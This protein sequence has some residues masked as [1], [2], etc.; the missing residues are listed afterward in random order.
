MVNDKLQ[1]ELNGL[2]ELARS[3]EEAN[4]ALAS[5]K[6][7]SDNSAYIQFIQGISELKSQIKGAGS[8]SYDSVQNDKIKQQLLEST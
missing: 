7:G 8:S 4:Q 3:L 1:H 6:F 2:R 5:S